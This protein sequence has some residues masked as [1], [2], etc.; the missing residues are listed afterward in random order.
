MVDKKFITKANLHVYYLKLIMIFI[1]FVLY[2]TKFYNNIQTCVT[3]FI[4]LFNIAFVQNMINNLKY[5][6]DL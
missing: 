3:S 5:N 6:N 2:E 1:I 4:I